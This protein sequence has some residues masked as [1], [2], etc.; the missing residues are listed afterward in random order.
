MKPKEEK[1]SEIHIV[2]EQEAKKLLEAGP[3][4]FDPIKVYNWNESI[5]MTEKDISN[6]LFWLF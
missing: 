5:V 2:G 4:L 3:A 6:E 1:K